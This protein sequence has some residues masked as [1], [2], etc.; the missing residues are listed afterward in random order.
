MRQ[1]SKLVRWVRFPSPAPTPH[2]GNLEIRISIFGF[3]LFGGGVPKW[4]NGADCKSA[5]LCL[6]WFESTPLHQFPFPICRPL[7]GAIQPHKAC[8]FA[9]PGFSVF[10]PVGNTTQTKGTQPRG[11]RLFH[12]V[13]QPIHSDAQRFES[14]GKP[15]HDFRRDRVARSQQDAVD[16][17]V[18][19]DRR[20]LHAAALAQL[21]HRADVEVGRLGCGPTVRAAADL[22][23]DRP[24]VLPERVMPRSVHQAAATADAKLADFDGSA[25]AVGRPQVKVASVVIIHVAA[26]Y[27]SR[28]R[29][30]FRLR[31]AS[32]CGNREGMPGSVEM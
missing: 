29:V 22:A 24:G 23:S 11:Q 18:P 5:G 4:P 7:D 31:Q 3:P 26:S 28:Q 19:P 9:K 30:F 13:I 25:A 1:P 21:G 32:A 15:F 12:P 2:A 27:S 17:G 6:Q 16:Q 8:V 20:K 14:A 10:P